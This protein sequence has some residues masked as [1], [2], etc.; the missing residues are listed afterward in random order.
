MRFWIFFKNWKQRE[1]CCPCAPNPKIFYFH[2]SR[3]VVLHLP[4]S[5]K[6]MDR[7]NAAT[8]T[9]HLHF[10]S[11]SWHSRRVL[12]PSGSTAPG[13]GEKAGKNI[14]ATPSACP[15]SMERQTAQRPRMDGSIVTAGLY[16]Q[17]EYKPFRV[18]GIIDRLQHTCPKH[19]FRPTQANKVSGVP[20]WSLYRAFAWRYLTAGCAARITMTTM[21]AT[22]MTTTMRIS[23]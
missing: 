15:C 10:R 16:T 4:F 9:L 23:L 19:R 5:V 1:H 17:S 14:S 8:W 11:P 22:T 3:F 18:C 7:W 12:R 2:P 13:L 6:A 20:S 21:K